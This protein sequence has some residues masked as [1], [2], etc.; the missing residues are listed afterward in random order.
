MAIRI[1]AGKYRHRILSVPDD[2]VNI[3]PTKDRI[4]EAI[5]SALGDISNA[6]CLDLYAGS[7]AMGIEALSRDA[8]KVYFVDN[9]KISIK[10]VKNNVNSLKINENCYE[11]IDN[12]DFT[13][14]ENFK[15]NSLKFNIVF[16]DPPYEKGE[17]NEIANFLISN[18]LLAIDSVLV[19]ECNKLLNIE[20]SFFKKIKQYQYGDILVYICWR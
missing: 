14:L 18:E 5:F 19:F 12:S 7:G 15:L 6:I 8:K 11:I 13:A 3:R 4:R 16:I 20:T 17:Y 9:N 10:T 1:V 2:R